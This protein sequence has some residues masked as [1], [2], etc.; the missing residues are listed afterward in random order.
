[1]PLRF[2]LLETPDSP[3]PEMAARW[4]RAEQLGFDR[5][6]VA[7]H[8]GDYRNLAGPWF[9]GWITLAAMAGAT[10]RVRIGTLVANPILRHPVVLA[11][12]A[13]AVDHLSGGRLDLGIGTGVA[14]FDHAAVG[15]PY[16]SPGERVARF[17]EYVDV[18][19]RVLRGDGGA[20]E[21]RW[22]GHEGVSTVPGPAQSPRPRLTI[23]GQSPTVLRVAARHADRWNTHGPFD[24][25]LDTIVR[26]TREQAA[27]L[28]QLC[29]EAGRAGESVRRSLLLFAALDPWTTADPAARLEE[30][31]GRFTP[32]GFEEFVLFRPPG[33][34]DA[35]LERLALDVLPSLR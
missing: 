31:V 19:D 30:I 20:Y 23:G 12:A 11:K 21:G 6:W 34:G 5:V 7:D 35:A 33:G 13:L 8:T 28:E 22:Y 1:V 9:D 29:E 4:R 27:R 25:D 10:E 17:A 26:V 18:L 16:W 14:G 3:Y 24:A 2:E 32:L 15:E